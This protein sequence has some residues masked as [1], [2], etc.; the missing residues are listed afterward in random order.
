VESFTYKEGQM[1]GMKILSAAL[2]VSALLQ[3]SP[4]AFAEET[5][6]D[7]AERVVRE[8]MA[9]A[10]AEKA[11]N[12]QIVAEKRAAEKKAKESPTPTPDPEK[13]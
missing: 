2:C 7:Q 9:K 1:M 13:K 8:S 4:I 5:P 11:R 12:D 6:R 3:I 10:Q